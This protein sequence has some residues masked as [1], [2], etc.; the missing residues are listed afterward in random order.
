MGILAYTFPSAQL[1]PV[2]LI[3]LSQQ[4]PKP[5]SEIS[6]PPARQMTTTH[7]Q[8]RLERERREGQNASCAGDSARPSGARA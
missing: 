8:H 3:S 4:N 5:T 1:H 7:N 2:G 6:Q